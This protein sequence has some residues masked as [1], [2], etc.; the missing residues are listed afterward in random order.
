LPGGFADRV[1]R[2][3]IPIN[4]YL[5]EETALGLEDAHSK[6]SGTRRV[7]GDAMGLG[8]YN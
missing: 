4:K 2:V 1:A 5:K 6:L 7:R 3:I 8:V